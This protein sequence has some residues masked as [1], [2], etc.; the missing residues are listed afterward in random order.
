M[1][2]IPAELKYTK[3]H[4]WL[5]IDG[6]TGRVGITD[7]AQGELGD[8]VFVELPT[9]GDTLT[10]GATFGTVEAVKTVADLY[11]PVSG[12]VIQ[13]NEAMAENAEKVN[14][15]PYGGGW[16]IEIRIGD[17]AELP[18]LLSADAY[19]EMIENAG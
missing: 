18:D 10:R 7:Y 8:I 13:V 4:E 3:E 19:A 5:R 17:T 9:V 6:D 11:A 12:E 2:E 16:M 15:E 14:S 1:S